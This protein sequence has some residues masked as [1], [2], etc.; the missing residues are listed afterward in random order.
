MKNQF[1][2][3]MKNQKKKMIIINDEEK[4]ELKSILENYI[5][6]LEEYMGNEWESI[7]TPF[8]LRF[9]DIEKLREIYNGSFD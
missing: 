4:Q 3:L 5:G 8:M 7:V 2:K 9:I 6:R 1:T